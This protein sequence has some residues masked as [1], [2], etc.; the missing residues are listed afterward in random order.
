[1]VVGQLQDEQQQFFPATLS[2]FSKHTSM[3]SRGRQALTC[4]FSA[5]PSPRQPKAA[6]PARR[7]CAAAASP[8]R[9]AALRCC[10]FELCMLFKAPGPAASHSGREPPP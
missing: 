7:R 6:R 10:R 3:F 8:R 1:M 4:S 9:Q 2:C 5:L